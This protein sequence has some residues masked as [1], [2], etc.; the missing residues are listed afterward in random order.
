MKFI[1]LINLTKRLLGVKTEEIVMAKADVVAA[2]VAAVQAG[3]TQVLSDQFSSVFDQAEAQG[4]GPGF[5]QADIDAAVKVKVDADALVLAQSQADDKAAFDSAMAQSG[6]AIAELQ[7][8][9]DALVL[10]EGQESGIIA[11]LKGS[12]QAI[13]DAEASLQSLFPA[14]VDP[15]PVS[16]A[17]AA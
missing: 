16:P 9:F 11:G 10:K 17:P 8:K 1:N 12:L 6:S 2:A 7:A 13:K 15:V 14:P 3:Q 4:T 5:T